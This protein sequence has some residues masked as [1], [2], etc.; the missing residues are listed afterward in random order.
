MSAPARYADVWAKVENLGVAPVAGLETPPPKLYFILSN[1]GNA[2][3]Q[4]LSFEFE[5]DLLNPARWHIAEEGQAIGTL[6]PGEQRAFY[7]EKVDANA[8]S[9]ATCHIRL[10]G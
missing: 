8:S 10:E 5:D 3:A 1:I 2:P 6:L 9:S 4:E 7:I